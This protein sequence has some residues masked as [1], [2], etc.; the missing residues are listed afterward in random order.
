V[1]TLCPRVCASINPDTIVLSYPFSNRQYSDEEVDK[2]REN[3]GIFLTKVHPVK[4]AV[5]KQI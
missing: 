2:Y 5:D 1:I 3:F 4:V